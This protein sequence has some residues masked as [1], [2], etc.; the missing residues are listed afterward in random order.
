M[1][2]LSP[3][4]II[5]EETPPP[6]KGRSITPVHGFDYIIDYYALLGVLRDAKP[7]EC[8]TA[9]KR[10]SKKWHP[11][12]YAA[13]AEPLRR[14]AEQHSKLL[15]EADE[16]LKDS[17]RR[18]R[19]DELLAS[20]PPELISTDGRRIFDPSR[21]R[22]DLQLLLSGQER[23][24][25]EV[26]KQLKTLS[27]F[28]ENTYTVL[29][30]LV[31]SSENPK[32][33]IL[34]AYQ[35]AVEKRLAF[36]SLKEELV[37]SRIG[38]DNQE[39]G[40][41]VVI[42]DEHVENRRVQLASVKEETSR[43]IERTVRL[44]GSNEAIRL[45]GSGESTAVELPAPVVVE[46][47]VSKVRERLKAEEASILE[48]AADTAHATAELLSLS[49]WRYEPDPP[50]KLSEELVIVVIHNDKILTGI[51]CK[52]IEGTV[53]PELLEIGRGM[54]PDKG[55]EDLQI[56]LG[57]ETTFALLNF[58]PELEILAQVVFVFEQHLKNFSGGEFEFTFSKPKI[59]N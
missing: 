36:L 57:K 38:I 8:H 49:K 54:S 28:D 41:K 59:E 44:L 15:V 46:N 43:A 29:K 16:I 52:N 35:A 21:R 12:K 39:A 13:L 2:D 17:D 51:R 27:G 42:P 14:Q 18:K 23:D 34:Q 56:V 40:N 25:S 58:N 5:K 50:Q 47:L 32:P 45:L 4:R 30:S 48:A 6:L 1:S 11:D 26:E 3:A 55:L 24:L 7:D 31:T 33:E 10:E 53:S 20:F 37:W 19:Y 9:F 22:V